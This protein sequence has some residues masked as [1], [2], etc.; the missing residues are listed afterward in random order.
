MFQS[1]Y[2]LDLVY[3]VLI[4]QDHSTGFENQVYSS[5]DLVATHAGVNG[6]TKDK[7]AYDRVLDNYQTFLVTMI[8]SVTLKEMLRK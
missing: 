7:D 8:I 3:N 1:K 4:F 6:K 5:E 2:S